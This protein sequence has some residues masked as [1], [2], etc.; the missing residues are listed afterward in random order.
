MG[1]SRALRRTAAVVLLIMGITVVGQTAAQASPGP[2]CTAGE[3]YQAT[4]NYYLGLAQ[5]Y[6]ALGLYSQAI[7]YSNA[8]T[9]YF[10][11][12]Y[13]NLAAC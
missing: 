3:E 2:S 1:W 5:A 9:F 12:A 13:V 10:R 8:A 11:L 7:D 6:R 4:G